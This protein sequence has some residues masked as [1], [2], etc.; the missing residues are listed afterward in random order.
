MVSM[1]YFNCKSFMAVAL[2]LHKFITSTMCTDNQTDRHDDDNTTS[3]EAEMV[4]TYDILAQ[5]FD[6]H[7]LSS[8]TLALSTDIVLQNS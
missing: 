3:V 8:L 2:F 6:I 4:K 5:K 7:V 1:K